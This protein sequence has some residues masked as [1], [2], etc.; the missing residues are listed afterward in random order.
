MVEAAQPFELRDGALAVG[1]DLG[2]AVAIA[3]LQR[4]DRAE[5]LLERREGGRVVLDAVGEVADLGGDV[6]E[7]RLEPGEPFRERL[8]ARVEAGQAA[9]LTDR[10]RGRL[11]GAGPIGGQ[12]VVDRG[13]SPG[14]RLAM[15]GRGQPRTDLVGLARPQPRRRDLG[16]LV[17]EEVH[18]AG[19]FAGLDREFGEGRPVGTPALDDI[20]HRGARR[21]VP[22]ERIEQVALPALV[23]EPLLVVLAVD[24]DE[25]P[26]LVGQARRG[27]RQV[28][29]PGG[30]SA[31]GRHLADGDE[32]L[33]EPIEERLDARRLGTVADQP[34]VRARTAHE[35]ERI[36]QQ[37]L[38]GAGL[39]GDDVETRSERQPQ[40][41]DEG[42]VADRQL[43][44]ASRAHEGSS[45]TLWRS[46][47]QNG[48]APSGAMSRIGRSVARTSTTSPTRTGMSSRPSTETSAS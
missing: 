8:E 3:A 34:G 9:C 33:G 24:L 23:E 35:S 15:L 32:R 25:R 14:D 6:V 2:L 45:A 20:G 46:R 13:R 30:R 42:Q 43:E 39:A 28:V 38:A 27:G 12:G 29:E 10:D 44:E 48:C 21:L 11:A 7:L 26:D 40:A 41:I 22:T 36:D 1:D 19:E 18:A 47:S 5:A 37:A 16:R 4:E 31:A 17:L